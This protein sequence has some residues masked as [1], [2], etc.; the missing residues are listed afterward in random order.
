MLTVLFPFIFGIV[1]LLCSNKITACSVFTINLGSDYKLTALGLLIITIAGNLYSYNKLFL[2]ETITAT[3]YSVLSVICILAEDLVSMFISLELMMLCSSILIFKG[4]VSFYKESIRASRQYLLTHIFSGSL[5]LI[6]IS[7][8]IANSHS[9]EII[10]LTNFIN[11][12]DEGFLIYVLMFAG[13]LINIAAFPFSGWMVNS[14]PV[15]SNAGFI[16]LISFTT[17]VSIIL[18]IKLFSGFEALKIFGVIMLLCGGIYA[19]IENNLKRLLCYLN[20]SQTGIIILVV[21][22]KTNYDI[23]PYIFVHILY[24]GLLSLL[25]M[26]IFDYKGTTECDD[27]YKVKNPL[28]IIFILFGIF[29]ITSMPLSATFLAKLNLISLLPDIIEN[30]ILV[31]N[32]LVFIGL[33]IREYFSAKNSHYINL[34][35]NNLLSFLIIGISLASTNLY[36]LFNTSFK[37]EDLVSQSIVI[38]LGLTLCYVINIKRKHTI[39]VNFDLLHVIGNSFYHALHKLHKNHWKIQVANNLKKNEREIL[40]KLLLLDNQKASIFGIILTLVCFLLIL[41]FLKNLDTE[42]MLTI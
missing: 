40:K 27:I 8:I 20:I 35:F 32:I 22:L 9:T 24:T 28:I 12:K 41:I 17:K 37:I 31:F 4:H 42:I 26:N 25:L 38:I 16:Y 23:I 1:L 10:N 39:V 7:Y 11:N 34:K 18:L 29:S 30:I 13:M 33:P 19:C 21:S 5:I 2:M 3:I 6:G 15:S 36:L 14:Y